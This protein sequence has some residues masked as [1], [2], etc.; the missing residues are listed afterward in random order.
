MKKVLSITSYVGSLKSMGWKTLSLSAIKNNWRD[1]IRILVYLLIGIWFYRDSYTYL[2]KGMT[3][4]LSDWASVLFDKNVDAVTG[5]MFMTLF[6][7]MV[8]K[9]LS[10][11][12]ICFL[13]LKILEQFDI[14]SIAIRDGKYSVDKDLVKRRATRVVKVIV[15]IATIFIFI[16]PFYTEYMKIWG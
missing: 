4:V 15:W 11:K 12:G 3:S 6:V 7:G 16:I 8:F 13:S 1:I 14:E 9:A 10:F 5:F 2:S